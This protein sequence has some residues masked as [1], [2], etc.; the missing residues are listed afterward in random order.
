MSREDFE[1]KCKREQGMN[2]M[3]VSEDTKCGLY[4]KA[5]LWLNEIDDLWMSKIYLEQVNKNMMKTV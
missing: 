3:D 4:I 5:S 1:K 2:I